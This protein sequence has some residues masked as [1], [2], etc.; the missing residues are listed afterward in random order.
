M[1]ATTF[2]RL[3]KEQAK[4]ELTMLTKS[5]GEQ[6]PSLRLQ[7]E[8]QIRLNF[9]DKFFQI[10][11][12]D[13]SSNSKNTKIVKDVI[14]EDT[15]EVDG[16][17][18]EPDYGFYYE[19]TRK[20]FVEAKRVTV[21]IKKDFVPAF[22]L[23]SYGY[24]AKLNISILTD[25]EEFSIYDTVYKPLETDDATVGRLFYTTY[26][27]YLEHF[28][29][30]WNTF[31]Y[32]AVENGLF[33]KYAQ[34]E[35]KRGA[36]SVDKDFVVSLNQWREILAKSIFKNNPKINSDDLNFAVTQI[37]DRVIFLRICEDKYI[38]PFG[39]LQNV[40]KQSKN[41]YSILCQIFRNAD[42]KYNSGLFDFRKDTITERLIIDDE[43]IT[44]FLKALYDPCPYRFSVMPI[45]VLGSA[46]E[47]FL[48]KAIEIDKGKIIIE[49]KSDVRK[50][51]GV[52]YT[53]QY[54]V[55]YILKNTIGTL[56]KDKTP[57][58]VNKIAICD[59][60]CGSGS[61]LVA[62]YQFLLNWHLEY[63][64]N[65]PKQ[66]ESKGE[67]TENKTLTTAEKKRILLNNI[68]GVDIDANAVEVTKLSLMLQCLEGETN[69]SITKSLLLIQERILPSLEKNILCGNSLLDLN[70]EHQT[71]LQFNT[72]F[73]R[74]GKS[75]NWQTKFKKVFENG[76]FD[77]IIGNPPYGAAFSK[78]EVNYLKDYYKTAGWRV[79]S[80]LLFC[81][82]AIKLLKNKGF[83]GYIIP[84]TYLNL[85][86]TQS[87]REFLL[88][89]SKIEEIVSLP[90]TVF[91][92]ATVDTTILIVGKEKY[93]PD[94][95][96]S[97][98]QVK[99]FAKKQYIQSV[100]N[101]QKKLSIST[102]LWFET[103]SFNIS[104]DKLELNLLNKLEKGITIE[105]IAE[106]N[107]G[108]KAY[109]VNKGK[110]KQTEK[111]RDE[112][113]FTS[114]T[115][116]GDKWLPFYDGK[117]IGRY[118]LLWNENNWINY[119][120]WLA[121]PRKPSVFEE[122]KIL[123]RKIIGQKLIATYIPFTSYC[124]TLLY[125]LKI[126]KN[127]KL[128][129]KALLGIL[130]SR[131][132][133]WYFRKKF[134]ISDE[135]T[136]PQIMIRDILQFYI[137]NLTNNWKNLINLVDKMLIYTKQY[138]STDNKAELSRLQ[139]HIDY[140]EMLIDKAVYELY[141]LNEDE[142]KIIES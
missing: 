52:F 71:E 139:E 47:Q 137:P 110:P 132:I 55:Q 85:G 76:G 61:F 95:H 140:T 18:K 124:N 125:V 39:N 2:K 122:E 24:S 6:L 121:E 91:E 114:D 136:F 22:Q 99:I 20:F 97:N 133:G 106:I 11:G 105:S 119:G 116:K 117:H 69:E 16:I 96:S 4:K 43:T 112:K 82:R 9:I 21:N 109:Q 65:N 67:L 15:V 115:K 3:N 87:L 8:T 93:K 19:A 30:L 89:N 66:K 63:Y 120:D 138:N 75:F 44:Q 17:L 32:E 42:S 142:I 101:P 72:G 27:K 48:G 84:D 33:D 36:A 78:D 141:G 57:N 35:V 7:K 90:S 98:V 49:T 86:F 104:S 58:D 113:P 29:F 129:Y 88:Q 81:E 13:V 130:N 134:Q 123:I 56:L 62:A 102:K 74:K 46:Y 40:Y 5:F 37:L 108:I 128:P 80:Y 83:L 12:W 131:L 77:I 53:P 111:I 41:K 127:V 45:D 50:A 118:S 34:S 68:Y 103:N 126:K 92:Q 1:A 54:I 107:Y 51:G 64:V 79:E 60:S 25:F 23:R 100:S 70:Y 59:P 14:Q 38:E 31:S 94:F 10:L 28:D 26:D 73:E 135:D